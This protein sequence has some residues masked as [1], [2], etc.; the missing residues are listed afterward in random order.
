[1]GA[2]F[3]K[4]RANEA[5]AVLHIW[6]YESD[7]QPNLN[8]TSSEHQ[9]NIMASLNRGE[10]NGAFFWAFSRRGGMGF[11]A[12]VPHTCMGIRAMDKRRLGNSDLDLTVIGF[13]AWAIGGGGWAYAWGAQDDKDSIDAIHAM[14]DQGV[15]WID[16]AH[17]YG[18]GHSEDIVGR[19]IAGREVIIATKCGLVPSTD[20]TPQPNLKRE[21]LRR[22]LEGSLKRLGVERIDLYQIH[23]PM[24]EEE[25]E[26]A[27]DEINK[28]KEE[29]KVRWAGV[30]N[31]SVEQMERVHKIAPI[32]SLQPPYSMLRRAVEEA[33][34]PW[35][36]SHNVGLVAYSPMQSGLLTGK[37]TKEWR[38]GLAE[39]DWRCRTK[40]FNEPNLS[41]NIEFVEKTLRPIADAHGVEPGQVA[42]AWTLRDEKITSAIVG[43]RS[44]RQAEATARAA[45]LKLSEDQLSAIELG[46]QEREERLSAAVRS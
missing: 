15:N 46:L 42:T 18:L 45:K 28:A 23:W 5:L 43:S 14:L 44:R 20:G 31:F 36:H 1:M 4:L 3:G 10:D 11:A 9:P 39:D 12:P 26:D 37:V 22:G 24:P 32:T 13:G 34:M 38:E 41:V 29:G 35:C 6:E 7:P 19:A 2:D 16:T 21:S 33:Q 27:W 40:E 17:V 8:R 30:S 25:I